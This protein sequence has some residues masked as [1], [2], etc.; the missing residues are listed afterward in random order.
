MTAPGEPRAYPAVGGHHAVP[1]IMRRCSTRWRLAE[2]RRPHALGNGT[3]GCAGRR[4]CGCDS[5][6]SPRPILR[7][8]SVAIR[9]SIRSTGQHECGPAPRDAQKLR[10][11]N[12]RSRTC[13]SECGGHNEVEFALSRRKQGFE[14]LGSANDFS[15]LVPK[16]ELSRP[17]SPTFLQWTVLQT[18]SS[19]VARCPPSRHEPRSHRGAPRGA[20]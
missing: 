13:W 11:P 20:N 7:S 12:A 4:H 1:S 9:S 3:R 8:Q 5:A 19:R 6:R 15:I 16:I 18:I 17:A 14:S 2:D 10:K